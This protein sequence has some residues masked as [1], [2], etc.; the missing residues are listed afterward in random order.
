MGMIHYYNYPETEIFVFDEFLICQ[1]RE[2][3]EIYPDHNLKLNDIIQTHFSGTNMVYISNRVNSYS[4][5]PLTYVQTEKIPNLKAIA[6]IPET[7]LMK[8]SAEFERDFYDKPYEIFSC[9]SDAI[10]WTHQILKNCNS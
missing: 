4:V 8:K 3:A 6:M 9:L 1:I 10:E 5:D 2:G 7:E